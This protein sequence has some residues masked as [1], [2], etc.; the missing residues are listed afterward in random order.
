MQWK[1]AAEI[2]RSLSVNNGG[3]TNGKV[4]LALGYVHNLIFTASRSYNYLVK[5]FF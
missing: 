2:F 4:L 3:P 1:T 5:L